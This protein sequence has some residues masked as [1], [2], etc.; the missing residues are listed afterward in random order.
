MSKTENFNV[1]QIVTFARNIA[2]SRN[3]EVSAIFDA[4]KKSFEKIIYETYDPDANLEFI[5]DEDKNIFKY[6]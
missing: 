3:L 1:Q 4:F 6:F 5:I 2:G